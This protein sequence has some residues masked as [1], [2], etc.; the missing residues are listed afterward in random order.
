M[1]FETLPDEV[2]KEFW[3]KLIS[4]ANKWANFWHVEQN[5]YN[6]VF[7]NQDITRESIIDSTKYAYQLIDGTK[8]TEQNGVTLD[9]AQII[10]FHSSKGVKSTFMRMMN[11]FKYYNI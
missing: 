6:T 2:L 3:E 7:V 10:H 5:I 8:Q 11:V 9:D 1:N 4:Y